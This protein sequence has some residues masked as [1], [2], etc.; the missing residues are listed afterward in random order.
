MAVDLTVLDARLYPKVGEIQAAGMSRGFD[1]RP[2]C[3]RRDPWQQ[4]R[5]WR[6]PKT[7]TEVE[8]AIKNLRAKSCPFLAD[9]LESV[10]PQNGP[11]V[12][13]ALPGLSW[14]QW[15]LAV[16]FGWYIEGDYSGSSVKLTPDTKGTPRNGYTVLAEV[17]RS[18]GLTS[19]ASWADYPH[20]QF[21]RDSSP[22]RQYT[23]IEVD[24]R[25]KEKFGHLAHP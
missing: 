16:D 25:M 14:H 4:A 10:G 3:A 21:P 17:A 15:D 22:Q 7:R 19:G 9:C 2:T 23:L 1:F 20:V 8:A 18:L 12:T 24:A 5:L 13:R 11:A 6:G